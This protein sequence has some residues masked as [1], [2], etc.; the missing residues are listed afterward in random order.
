MIAIGMGCL[1]FPSLAELTGCAVAT[2]QFSENPQG[3]P[4]ALDIRASTRRLNVDFG[5][6]ASRTI[7]QLQK[8]NYAIFRD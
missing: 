3:Q 4:T 2:R 5:V 6:N 1:V 8:R 7:A